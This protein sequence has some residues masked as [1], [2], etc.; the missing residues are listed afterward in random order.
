M[1]GKVWL[2]RLEGAE[3]VEKRK[4]R[5]GVCL[6]LDV[7]SCQRNTSR[8]EQK[9]QYHAPLLPPPSIPNLCLLQRGKSSAPA[10]QFF[11]MLATTGYEM[12]F[13]KIPLTIV[14]K[15]RDIA[16]S[17]LKKCNLNQNPGILHE[18][19]RVKSTQ[20]EDYVTVHQENVLITL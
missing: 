3:D 12:C 17:R 4:G 14:K 20:R 5:R 1:E 19:F 6:N 15:I 9:S 10:W 7:L 11:A 18:F 2:R 8:P 16:S 13:Q